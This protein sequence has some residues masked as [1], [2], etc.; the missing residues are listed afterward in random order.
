[1]WTISRVPEKAEVD[2]AIAGERFGALFIG[3]EEMQ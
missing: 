2:A 1:M 3:Q